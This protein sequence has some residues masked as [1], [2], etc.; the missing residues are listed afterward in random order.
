VKLTTGKANVP[1]EDF[2]TVVRRAQAGDNDAFADLFHQLHQ[3]ILNYVYRTVGDRQAAEDITQDAFIRA[4]ERMGQLGPPWDFKSWLYR[5]ASNLALDY[6]RKGRRFVDVDDPEDLRARPTTR[7]PA[8]RQ[9]QSEEVKR[10]VHESILM[11]PATYRQA[12][13]LRE[14]NGLSYQETA[15]AMECSYDNARQLVH[16]AR[17]N[18]REI[19]GLRMMAASGAVA[20]REL[21]DLLSAYQDGELD[22]DQRKSARKHIATCEHCQE[23]E[24]DLKKVMGLMGALI[25][26]SPSPGWAASVLEQIQAE[27]P[28]GRFD[29]PGDVSSVGGGSGGP[30]DGAGGGIGGGLIPGGWLMKGAIV[31]GALLLAGGLVFLVSGAAI[32][33]MGGGNPI[34][35]EPSPEPI[36]DEAI[37]PPPEGEPTKTSTSAPVSEAQDEN[38]VPTFTATS[39]VSATACTAVVVAD[40]NATCRAG[41]GQIW[42]PLGYLLQGEDA[43]IDGRDAAGN[44]WWIL[45]PDAQGH[46]W[47]WDGA[48]STVCYDG[49]AFIIPA[50]PTPTPPDTQPPTISVSHAP[51]DTWRPNEDDTVTITASASD[52]GGV[53]KIEVWVRPPLAKQFQLSKT[54]TN[55][56]S[57]TYSGGPYSPGELYYYAKAWDLAGNDAS[58]SQISTTVHVIVR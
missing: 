16:R 7:R 58:S 45:N 47:V 49:E 29:S 48:V 1:E 2:V 13:L 34:P 6:L 4:H 10:S 8:E 33:L 31:L 44:W 42:D 19:H 3:P 28:A 46:C 21:D 18:F 36:P 24:D 41:P 20:C 40:V 14:I 30:G 23:T 9:V 17:L 50:P 38:S 57:C 15:S 39:T 43:S 12:L 35:G 11:M 22:V 55:I 37:M 27:V 25:P 5:I 54:C 53:G 52:S 26:I 51:T 56:A 32:T